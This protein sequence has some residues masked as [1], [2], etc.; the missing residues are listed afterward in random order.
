MMDVT[1]K[2][3]WVVSRNVRSIRTLD[4]LRLLSF[5]RGMYCDLTLLAGAAWLLI[6]WTP[7]GITV[8]EIV[9]LL[10]T[11]APLPRNMLETETCVVVA[12]LARSGFVRKRPSGEPVRGR[13]NAPAQAVG[14]G[15]T[16]SVKTDKD[17]EWLI[18]PSTLATYTEDGAV[19]LDVP[20]G[21]L[22]RPKSCASRI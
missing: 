1:D 22:L 6:K 5:D 19:V 20:E 18:S 15:G 21:H 16:R 12:D 10:E 9:D 13:R 11:A 4:R 14:E 2:I 17:V 3:F 7:V 8:N